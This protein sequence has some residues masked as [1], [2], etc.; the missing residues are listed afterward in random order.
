MLAYLQRF[1]GLLNK[2]EDAKVFGGLMDSIRMA[3]NKKF[4][5]VS[6]KQ[7][8]NNT[9]TANLLPLYFGIGPGFFKGNRL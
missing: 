4:Y 1:A 2:K 3:F 8:S 6:K 7:Y 9:V 5:D